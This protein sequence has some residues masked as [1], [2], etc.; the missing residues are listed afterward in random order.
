[1]SKTIGV[2]EIAYFVCASGDLTIEF[3]ANY[4]N[5]EGHEAHLFLQNKYTDPSQKEVYVKKTIT[6]LNEEITIN[7]FIDGVLFENKET[8]IEEIKSTKLELDQVGLNYH[9]EYLAQLKLY[10]Y[11]YGI[12]HNLINVHLR[13]T[14]ISTITYETKS[15]DLI[16]NIDE[17]EEFFFK[18]CEE[19]LTFLHDVD[20][21]NE[22]RIETI[23]T[24]K[25]PF[26]KM[27]KGQRDLMAACFQTMK[28][29]DILFSIAPTGVGKTMATIF[30]SL[31]TLNNKE[32]KLFYLTAKG[33]GKKVAVSAINLLYTNGLKMK[34]I[35]LTAKSKICQ[36]KQKNCNP[37]ACPLAKGFFTR[38]KDA[39][40]DI[41]SYDGIYDYDTILEYADKHQICAFEYSLELS[42]F[43]DLIIADYNYTF[44]PKAHLIRYFDDSAYKP[45]IL[46]DEAHNLVDR[47]KD[48]YSAVIS[49]DI[50]KKLRISL[51]GLK[52]SVRKD[53]NRAIEI[54]EE[55]EAK[56]TDAFTYYQDELD[57]TLYSSLNTIARKCEQIFSDNEEFAE[58]DKALEA[59]F[60]IYDFLR[61]CDLYDKVHKTLV[62]KTKNNNFIMTLRCFDA[63][64]FIY[65]TIKAAC[66]GVVFF[67]A[68]LF[69]IK[70]YMD[71]LTGGIGKYLKLESPFDP[72]NLDLIINDKISTKYQE[73][74]A[75]IDDILNTLDILTSSEDGN[76][77]IFFP[78]YQYMQMVVDRL[79]DISYKCFIQRQSMTENERDEI[80]KEFFET[81]QT[82]VGFFVMGGVFSEG[83]DYI[84]DLLKGVIIVGVGLP[85]ICLENDLS[86]EY[87]DNLYNDGFDYAYTYPGFNKVVQAAGRVIRSE[88]DYG[89]VLLLDY[90]Y[91]YKIYQSLMPTSWNNK[92]YIS[93]TSELKNELVQFWKNKNK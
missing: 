49:T 42:N 46:V 1:M 63:S 82:K 92:K 79:D 54:L 10:G 3:Q 19:Y 35:V 36:V 93:N 39:I 88:N 47:S 30:S 13:L 6:I 72:N 37:K 14:F 81:K 73:R 61:I 53:V 57:T 20:K 59:Y 85:L 87:F 31:K 64:K 89:V 51:T 21:A 32:D 52:P 78:S 16:L 22:N 17:L 41:F 8:I 50:L 18:C 70:Y 66:H 38:L 69:P 74:E 2:K 7:G 33:M 84:G 43:C 11:L 12:E 29:E 26:E 86:K 68:T 24:I 60:E 48:M 28:N 40:L 55:Y 75:S 77:I 76:Y 58:K 65:Q 71:L 34:A 5:L 45:K 80:F 4:Q 91:R 23:K 15:F 56:L 25:F 90:R 62:T 67:S 83:L 27:R 44:D 9:N